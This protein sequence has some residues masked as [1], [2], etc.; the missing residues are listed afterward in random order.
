MYATVCTR[1]YMA[2]LVGVVSEYMVNR[3]KDHWE[4]AKCLLIYLRGTSITSLFFFCK[5]NV[6]LQ[7]FVDADLGGDVDSGKS[8][9]VYISHRWNNSELDVQ[10]SEL[11]FSFIY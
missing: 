8:T 9:S 5:G 1:P 11:C 6:T 3:W 2:H 10:A 4:D 7:S